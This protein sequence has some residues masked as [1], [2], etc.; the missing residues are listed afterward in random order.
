M[1]RLLRIALISGLVGATLSAQGLGPGVLLLARVKAHIRAELARL[2]NCS[3]LQTIQRQRRPAGGVMRPLDTV[4]LEVLFSDHKEFF[5]SPGE[6]R[7]DEDRPS[8]FTAGGLIGNGYFALFLSEVV[9]ESGPSYEYQGEETVLGRTLAR[10]GYR[11]PANISGHTLTLAEGTGTV[12]IKGRFWADPAT[13]DIVR[14][15]FEAEDIPPN[16]PVA[17]YDVSVDYLRTNLGG[18]E[19]FLPNSADTSMVRFSGEESRNHTEFTHCRLFSAQSSVS[20]GAPDTVTQFGVSSV[21]TEARELLPALPIVVKVQTPVTGK[22]AV[23]SVLDG[24]VDGDVRSNGKVL[25]PS[26]SPVRGRL[27]R[28]EWHQEK[29]GYFIVAME[30]TEI[31]A[32][33]TLYRFFA[34]LVDTALFPGLHPS[35][36]ITTKEAVVPRGGVSAIRTSSEVLTLPE[37]PGVGSFFVQAARLEIPAGFRMTWK[38]RALIP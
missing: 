38:T 13:Y 25:I 2:P 35:L 18:V 1:T 31:D 34:D 19:Y 27:R 15:S 17:R 21:H 23:G 36:N 37:T 28:L 10:Y 33:G 11:I 32:A 7:F 4:R 6:R 20:F 22:S 24:V 5:A 26:G 16:L 14:I 9:A 8:A 30:F 29:G 12:G 3:C